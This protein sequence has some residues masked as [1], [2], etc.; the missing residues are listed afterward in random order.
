V[1]QERFDTQKPED[2][3]EM[4]IFIAC[5]ATPEPVTEAAVPAPASVSA[6]ALWRASDGDGPIGLVGSNAWYFHSREEPYGVF[7]RSL[8][9]SKGSVRA[10][11][12]LPIIGQPDYWE[13]IPGGYLTKWDVPTRIDEVDGALSVGWQAS[14][15]RWWD[16]HHIRGDVLLTARYRPDAAAVALSLADGAEVWR[17][18]L[19]RESQGTSF[20]T[21]ADTLYVT[22][23]EYD[24]QAPTPQILI[25]QRIRALDIETGAAKWTVDFAEH[26]GA[27][28]ASSGVV[29]AAFD[30]DLHFIDG[31]TGA[32]TVVPTGQHPNIYPGVLMSAD[33]AF[34]ALNDAVT[35]Y[36]LSGEVRWRQPAVFDGGPRLA[37]GEHLL[38][39]TDAG[40]VLALDPAT[41]AVAWEIGVG[42]GA[43]NILL[44]EHV[45]LVRAGGSA[46][47][48]ALPATIPAEEATITGTV[49][50]D[51]G[52]LGPVRIGAAAVQPDAEGRYTLTVTAA[53]YVIVS[54]S[55]D[56]PFPDMEEQRLIPGDVRSVLVRLDGSGQYD[57][58]PLTIRLCEGE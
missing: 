11:D 23:T 30:A 51:C 29:L 33:T 31:A 4:W 13:G 18:P 6:S 41:G 46:A 39:T 42:M 58:P 47:G 24:P 1:I 49:T 5:L 26:P 34:V 19:P 50:I 57:A 20:F 7:P 40:T 44:N 45:A 43:Y 48:I 16:A 3:P 53:G 38:V 22:W 25:P 15:G 8:D 9:G 56:A 17:S 28:Y 10:I 35:A 14:D 36:D 55:P 32:R 52:K 37:L 54:A 21:D 27:L 2:R 12:G